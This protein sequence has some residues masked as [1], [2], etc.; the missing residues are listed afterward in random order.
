M[1]RP[2]VVLIGEAVPRCVRSPARLSGL[3]LGCAGSSRAERGVQPSW[4]LYVQGQL[5]RSQGRNPFLAGVFRSY[6][7]LH[8]S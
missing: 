6:Q 4:I 3:G 8:V 2:R 5:L 1:L 7:W